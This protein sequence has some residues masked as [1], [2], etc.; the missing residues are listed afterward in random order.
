MQNNLGE[1]FLLS[2]FIYEVVF[3][4]IGV[5]V[6]CIIVSCGW[7]RKAIFLIVT[8]LAFCVCVN[9]Y[10]H[11][12]TSKHII[13]YVSHLTGIKNVLSLFMRPAPGML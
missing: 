10:G 13:N 8:Y 12:C 3:Y 1:Q 7:F 9:I 4:V 11:V 5:A 2:L 6:H